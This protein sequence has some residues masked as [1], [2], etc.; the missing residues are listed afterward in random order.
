MAKS[1]SLKC[2][3]LKRKTTELSLGINRATTLLSKPTQIQISNHVV[4]RHK[5]SEKVNKP[6]GSC[7][8]QQSM[9]REFHKRSALV[10]SNFRILSKIR[11]MFGCDRLCCGGPIADGSAYRRGGRIGNIA[12]RKYSVDAGFAFVVNN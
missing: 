1:K 4:E 11:K 2:N 7:V 5:Y 9:F 3:F 6:Y 8:S 12:N 10:H